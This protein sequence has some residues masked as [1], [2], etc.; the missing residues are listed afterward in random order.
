MFL[1]AMADAGA[2]AAAA[3]PPPR[4][5][6]AEQNASFLP[7][8]LLSFGLLSCACAARGCRLCAVLLLLPPF[9]TL[10]ALLTWRP[11]PRCRWLP[12]SSDG[13]P[14]QHAAAAGG[15][16]DGDAQGQP[17]QQQADGAV[18]MAADGSGA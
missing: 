3:P 5:V 11:P 2:A 10:L 15:S 4:E 8:L 16:A 18:P 17:Q 7:P 9:S 12:P 14:L 13:Q 6:R 1:A